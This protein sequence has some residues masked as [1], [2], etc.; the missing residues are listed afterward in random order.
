MKRSGVLFLILLLLPF[1]VSANKDI[2]TLQQDNN[3]WVLQRQHYAAQGYSTLNQITTENVKNLKVAWSFSL[4]TLQGQ[5]GGPLVVGSTMYVHSSFPNNVYALDL[6]KPGAPIIWSYHPK[7]DAKTGKELWKVRN[8]DPGKG[9]TYTGQGLI[10]KDKFITGISGGEFGVRGWVVA[11]DLNTGKQLRKAYSRG[12]DEDLRLAADFNNAN[13][14]FG[15]KGEGTKTWPGEQWK[16]GGGTTWGYWSYDPELNLF[17]YGTG[18][19]G[20]W[21]PTPRKGA[22]K[23]SMTIWARNP[24][25]GEAKWAYQMTPWD[26]WDYDGVKEGILKDQP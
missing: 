8:G 7:Q 1:S 4:G 10:I 18:N 3:Q 19:P 5:E 21:N 22:N 12:P 15:Q 26:A 20:T 24:D 16:I 23:G 14:H 25:T 2:L 6:T 11:Y 17:Y 9:E 13:P